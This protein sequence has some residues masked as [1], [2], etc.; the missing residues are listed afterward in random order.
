[1]FASPYFDP[2][3]DWTEVAVRAHQLLTQTAPDELMDELA[4]LETEPEELDQV[5]W[6]GPAA[7]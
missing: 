5:V 6:R 1:V 3:R 7:A 4:A 2:A